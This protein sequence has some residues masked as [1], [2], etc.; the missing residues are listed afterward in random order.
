MQVSAVNVS[1]TAGESARIAI[2]TSWSMAK[3]RSCASVRFG[4]VTWAR[5]SARV[6]AGAAAGGQT[7]AIGWPSTTKWPGPVQQPDH[8]SLLGRQAERASSWRT[9]WR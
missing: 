7:T 2:S 1:L 5:W 9:N 6:T 3:A 4:P 8:R